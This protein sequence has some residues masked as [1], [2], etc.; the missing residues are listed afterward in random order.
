ME[1]AGAEWETF[2]L[3][4]HRKKKVEGEEICY[5][6]GSST[7]T[8]SMNGSRFTLNKQQRIVRTLESWRIVRKCYCR[9]LLRV[10][11]LKTG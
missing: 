5:S 2:S 7:C 4:C 3:K 8:L 9:Y 1:K 10:M 11:H 6:R